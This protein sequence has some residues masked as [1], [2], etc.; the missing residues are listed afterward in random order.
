M[1]RQGGQPQQQEVVQTRQEEAA[2]TQTAAIVAQPPAQLPQAA[3]RTDRILAM[4]WDAEVEGDRD[5]Q[6]EDRKTMVVAVMIPIRGF[7]PRG[8]D[9]TRRPNGAYVACIVGVSWTAGERWRQQS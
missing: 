2:T 1:Q 5:G 8:W 7:W 6:E 9:T 4:P 3:A